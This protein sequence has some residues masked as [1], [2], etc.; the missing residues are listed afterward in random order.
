MNTHTTALIVIGILVWIVC[1]AFAVLLV[2]GSR[3][4]RHGRSNFDVCDDCELMECPRCGDVA[5][6]LYEVESRDE[7]GRI[8]TDLVCASCAPVGGRR[9]Y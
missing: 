4:C 9:A 6:G 8:E 2:M 3:L 1:A 5:E 7:F